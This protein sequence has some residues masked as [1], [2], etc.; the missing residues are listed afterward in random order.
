MNRGVVNKDASF[1]HHR[2]NVAKAQRVCCVPASA[3]QHDFQRIVQPLEN[4][5]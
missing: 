2:F 4:L 1:L 5:A 3:H